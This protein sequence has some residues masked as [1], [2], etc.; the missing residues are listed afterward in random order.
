[1]V[2]YRQCLTLWHKPMPSK[3]DT[4]IKW[5]RSAVSMRGWWVG[6]VYLRYQARF[7][8]FWCIKMGWFFNYFGIDG[9]FFNA[10]DKTTI[11]KPFSGVYSWGLWCCLAMEG[12]YEQHGIV[13]SHRN[14]TSHTIL[15]TTILAVYDPMLL[16]R[17]KK[18]LTQQST[19]IEE[20]FLEV[21]AGDGPMWQPTT[22]D[23]FVFSCK[24]K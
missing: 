12:G 15:R 23:L 16:N 6:G 14:G 5:G 9:P 17:G 4:T 18:A 10:L 24:I 1:M 21:D 11:N 2:H 7:L 20:R 8:L 22:W 19:S 3:D 13:F